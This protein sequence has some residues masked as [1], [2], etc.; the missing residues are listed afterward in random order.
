LIIGLIGLRYLAEFGI[1]QFGLNAGAR[2][3]HAS[4]ATLI[5]STAMLL[6]RG[7]H[8]WIKA[9]ALI[10]AHKRASLQPAA[11]QEQIRTGA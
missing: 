6:A 11:P 9:R 10:A 7:V 4:D 2:L 3:I 5:F 1:R 8:T